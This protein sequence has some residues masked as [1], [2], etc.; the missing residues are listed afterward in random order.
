MKFNKYNNRKLNKQKGGAANAPGG[1]NAPGNNANNAPAANAPAA[2]SP[3]TP[4]ANAPNTPAANAPN[5]PTANTPPAAN[6]PNTPATNNK[7]AANKLENKLTGAL[8]KASNTISKLGSRASNLGS[9]VRNSGA[10][11]GKVFRGDIQYKFDTEWITK[12][13][14][15]IILGAILL[16][17]I[18]GLKHLIVYIYF[19]RTSSKALLPGTKSGKHLSIIR[20]D[21]TSLNYIPV[22]RSENEDGIEFTY[23]FWI[24]INDLQTYKYNEWKHVFHKGNSTSYPN[25]APGVWIHPNKNIIRFYMNTFDEILEYVDVHDIPVKKWV[26]LQVVLQNV[27]SHS[28]E[29]EDLVE[30]KKNQVLDVYVNG[31]LKQSK[32]LSSLP[33]QN[34]GD[35]YMNYDGGYDGFLS[36]LSYYPKALKYNDIKKIVREGPASLVTVDTGEVPPYLNDTWW[37]NVNDNLDTV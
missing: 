33:R 4:A 27:N 3:N 36:K 21:P 32:L 26:C 25:R 34:N 37:Y 13:L 17:I 19:R 28:E 23:S 11:V 10:E 20:Q 2:N 5:T 14:M 31:Q 15:I 22:E 18:I 35:I 7:T 29:P 6:A 9:K 30:K 12:P 16:G 8:G 1:N 24:M